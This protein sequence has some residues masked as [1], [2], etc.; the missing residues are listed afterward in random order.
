[1]IS[2][3]EPKAGGNAEGEYE[4]EYPAFALARKKEVCPHKCVFKLSRN[5]PIRWLPGGIALSHGCFQR[6]RQSSRK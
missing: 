2:F 6:E 5:G 3:P 1:M 4:G